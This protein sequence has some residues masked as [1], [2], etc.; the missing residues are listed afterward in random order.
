MACCMGKGFLLVKF[1][2]V[3]L[4]VSVSSY[5]QTHNQLHSARVCSGFSLGMVVIPQKYTSV[6]Y[7]YGYTDSLF[8]YNVHKLEDFYSGYPYYFRN[9]IRNRVE[10]SYTGFYFPIFT[11]LIELGLKV[12]IYEYGELSLFKN[13]TVAVCGNLFSSNGEW[14]ES[15]EKWGGLI[16]STT[17]RFKNVEI[18]MVLE[19]FYSNSKE[20]TG[21]DSDGSEKRMESFNLSSGLV[22]RLDFN[23]EN[24]FYFEI[25]GGLNWQHVFDSHFLVY[26]YTP[27]NVD[28]KI[29]LHSDELLNANNVGGNVSIAFNWLKKKR[30]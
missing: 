11:V 19:P 23:P 25:K 18:E 10:V 7:K 30:T 29:L 16:L 21:Y 17:H 4:V 22:T 15:S 26:A 14:D 28:R 13:F 5:C 27:M 20:H 9:G 12:K 1:V 24:R 2:I 3:A 8:T 6:D